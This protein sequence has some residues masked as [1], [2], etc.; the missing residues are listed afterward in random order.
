[1][2]GA[3]VIA[4]PGCATRTS[5]AHVSPVKAAP[6]SCEREPRRITHLVTVRDA[7]GTSGRI[8]AELAAGAPVYLCETNGPWRRIMFAA[9][10]D[11]VDCSYR[12]AAHPCPAGW[13]AGTMKTEVFD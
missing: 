2:A 11:P 10:G 8:I 6:A 1:M 13:T 7:P 5:G 4:A 9:P 12:S 3:I